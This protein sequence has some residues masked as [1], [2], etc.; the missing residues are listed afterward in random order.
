MDGDMSPSGIGWWCSDNKIT[1]HLSLSRHS[2]VDTWLTYASDCHPL[3]Y[4]V[5]ENVHK[6]LYEKQNTEE[7]C[8]LMQL[9]FNVIDI[10]AKVWYLF[11]LKIVFQFESKRCFAVE[12][13]RPEQS[14]CANEGPI[15]LQPGTHQ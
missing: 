13:P 2:I 7:V 11:C 4:Q 6:I 10:C 14:L 1:L 12:L 15:S 8:C 3:I 9:H 5:K